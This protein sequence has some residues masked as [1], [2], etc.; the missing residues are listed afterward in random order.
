MNKSSGI[1]M[2]LLFSFILF[3]GLNAT[4]HAAQDNSCWT[5]PTQV[6]FIMLS[7]AD[8]SSNNAGAEAKVNYNH[9]DRVSNIICN[10][11]HGQYEYMTN[12]I[13]YG[14]SIVRSQINPGI[15][16]KLSDEIDIRVMPEG[17]YN[18]APIT[19]FEDFFR[20]VAPPF[21]CNEC[22]IREI[23]V[24]GYGQFNMRLRKDIVGGA[25]VIP[26]N[27]EIL[28][29]YRVG[30]INPIPPKPTASFFKLLTP[31]SGIVIPIPTVCSINNGN[32]LNVAFGNV[33][34]DTIGTSPSLASQAINVNLSIVCNTSLTQETV[35]R[36]VAASTTFSDELM[37]TSNSNL[38][39]AIQ[40][41]G[42]LV[43]PFGT[44]PIRLKNGN[45]QEQITLYPVKNAAQEPKEGDFTASATLIVESL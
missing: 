6:F 22:V 23:I 8:F 39:I 35:I 24:S 2:I 25:I 16:Y 12:Y 4:T 40:H 21:P 15:W 36:L 29:I 44:F 20:R 34:T 5:S 13:D 42:K 43:K 3:F 1:T 41:N 30:K 9:N 37:A 32:S 45:G 28:R 19:A 31:P 14:P 38:G 33:R 18:P 27:V 11:T 10:N 17:H 26:A 7:R